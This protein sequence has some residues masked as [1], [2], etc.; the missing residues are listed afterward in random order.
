MVC[1]WEIDRAAVIICLLV[2]LMTVT[3][4]K[5]RALTTATTAAAMDTE[6][7]IG[8]QDSVLKGKGTPR[9]WASLPEELVR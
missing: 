4:L 7:A 9:S 6:P 3:E 8:I 2:F 5:M 1:A